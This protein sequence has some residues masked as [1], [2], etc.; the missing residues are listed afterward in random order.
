MVKGS[1]RPFKDDDKNSLETQCQ[2][3]LQIK[4]LMQEKASL[5]LADY[6]LYVNRLGCLTRVQISSLLN[7]IP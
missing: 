3:K 6:N 5:H 4:S 2:I 1:D 7:L